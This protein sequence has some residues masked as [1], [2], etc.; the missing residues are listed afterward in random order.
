MAEARRVE[1][2]VA[3]PQ[4]A[5]RDHHVDEQDADGD[6]A[7]QR[8]KR[9]EERDDCCGMKSTSALHCLCRAQAIDAMSTNRGMP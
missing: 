3:A 1:A 9:R 8:V 4:D 6:E 5:L 2:A 7:Q